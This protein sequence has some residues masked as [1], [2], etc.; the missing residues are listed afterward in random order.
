MSPS[1]GPEYALV[2]ECILL[3]VPAGV[4]SLTTWDFLALL[5]PYGCLQPQQEPASHI[6]VILGVSE[7]PDEWSH[8]C[9]C[10]QLSYLINPGGT[11]AS[12]THQPLFPLQGNW[13]P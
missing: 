3:P 10:A 2:S 8:E 11:C 1:P 5:P 13:S 7:M 4:G 9:F 6:P 12:Y